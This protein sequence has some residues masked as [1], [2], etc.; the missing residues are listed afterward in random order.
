MTE[1]KITEEFC[2]SVSLGSYAKALAAAQL[3]M[4]GARK[5][6]QN[7]H[8]KNRYSTLED[9]IEAIRPLGEHGIAFQQVPFTAGNNHVGVI[10]IFIHESG[11]MIVSKC[12]MPVAKADPQGHG[13]AYTYLRRYALMAMAGIAP[14]DDDGEAAMGRKAE[15]KA[16]QR[17]V[18]DDAEAGCVAAFQGARTVD[19][20]AQ[21]EARAARAVADGALTNEARKRLRELR[22]AAVARV[23]ASNGAAA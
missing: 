13:S 19:D 16:E 12:A 4:S 3:K 15:A 5:T 6:A 7:P 1:M 8:L 23:A 9:V 10:T 2:H 21:A 17:A 22:A 11:E 20:I 14:V 18:S